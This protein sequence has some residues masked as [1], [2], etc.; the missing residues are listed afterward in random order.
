MGHPPASHGLSTLPPAK[1]PVV[2]QLGGLQ[3]RWQWQFFLLLH[4]CMHQG[5]QKASLLVQPEEPGSLLQDCGTHPRIPVQT[6]HPAPHSYTHPFQHHFH[7]GPLNP[8]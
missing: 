5:G 1:G 2:S 6:Q 3:P 4:T 7:D 8:P